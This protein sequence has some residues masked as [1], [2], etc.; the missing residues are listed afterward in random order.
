MVDQVEIQLLTANLKNFWTDELRS[1]VTQLPDSAAIHMLG[2]FQIEVA[3]ALPALSGDASPVA[4]PVFRDWLRARVVLTW[5]VL[6]EK[7][8]STANAADYLQV[9]VFA[10]S[11]LYPLALRSSTVALG[12]AEC[13]VDAYQAIN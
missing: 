11:I 10:V 5:K 7:L 1:D 2:A 4:V 13:L 3:A 12:V 8:M 6:F 9:I